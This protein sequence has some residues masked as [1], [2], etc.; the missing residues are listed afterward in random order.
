L[1]AAINIYG[2]IC[3]GFTTCVQFSCAYEFLRVKMCRG[4]LGSAN[5]MPK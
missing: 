3:M 4:D 5:F 2:P 1:D